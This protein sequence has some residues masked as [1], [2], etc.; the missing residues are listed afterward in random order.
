MTKR[1]SNRRSYSRKFLLPGLAAA[2]ALAVARPIIPAVQALPNSYEWE[3]QD[4]LD[5]LG[6]N[7]TSSAVSASGNYMLVGVEWGGEGQGLTSPLYVTS[8]AGATWTDVKDEVEDGIRNNWSSVDVSNNGQV[9]VAASESRK[10]VDAEEIDGK[11]HKSEDAG[12]TWEDI[13]PTTSG[14]DGWDNVVVSGNGNKIVAT[15]NSDLDTIYYSNNGGDD[16]STSSVDTVDVWHS[17][18]VSDDGS[19]VLVGG[20]A[21][22]ESAFVYYS[23]NG[24][25]TWEDVAPTPLDDVAFWV[26]ADMSADGS[27]LV[28]SSWGV[29]EDDVNTISVSTN[30]GDAWSD[31]TPET[32][33]PYPWTE[34]AVSDDGS[35]I[36]ASDYTDNIFITRDGGANWNQEDTDTETED[37][38]SFRT[39][40]INADGT[41][42]V[43]AGTQNAYVGTGPGASSAQVSLVNAED[44][45]AVQI[46]TPDGTTI[47]CSSAVKESSLG[48]QD[49]GYTYPLGLVDF[50]FDTED[51]S[52]P[53]TLTFVTDLTPQQVVVRKYNPNT[54]TYTSVTDASIAETTYEG[55]HAIQVT[56]TIVDNGPLDMDPDEG[57]IADPV[58]LGVV[59]AQASLASTGQSATLYLLIAASLITAGLATT[60]LQKNRR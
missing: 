52:N 60:R 41:R 30:G 18:S 45:K 58:G 10:V 31:I 23:T 38:D 55:Q 46:T 49:S 35:S 42:A 54:K 32:D 2:T 16:W 12:A 53:V 47:T 39:L 7:F 24:G 36:M 51:A 37:A 5:R 22:D 48:A 9:M 1:T 17:L 27:K 43:I 3:R 26:D 33:D 6:G 15:S 57:E 21:E 19:K 4:E 34:L 8:N 25:S 59:A 20:E 40:D 56:Y 28:V 11:I 29:E 44:G 14:G 13:T 50:C